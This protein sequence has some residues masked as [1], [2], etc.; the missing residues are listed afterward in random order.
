MGV[1]AVL[2]LARLAIEIGS[3]IVLIL[4]SLILAIGFQPAV[5]WLV[6]RGLSRALAVTAI[7]LLG[8]AVVGAFLALVLPDIV[9]SV[10]GLI[11]AAPEYLRRAQG[12]GGLLAELN[13]RFDLASRLQGVGGNL[14]GTLLGFVQSFGALVFNSL[15]ILIL[16][17]YFTVALPRIRAWFARLLAGDDRESFE[18]IL[19]QSTQRVG[20]YVLGMFVVSLTAGVTTFVAMLLIGVPHAAAL[21]FFVALVDLIPTIG[22]L[23][24]AV[25]A[26]TVAAIG[27]GI[28]QAI[29]TAAFFL[30]Y[31][32]VE[33]YLIHPRVMRRAIDMPAAVVIIAVL[34]GATLLGV[35]GALLAIP[36][37]AVIRVAFRELY[38]EDRLARV[39]SRSR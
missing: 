3:I 10:A 25:V 31:Q 29:A 2:A 1:L 34:I 21:A 18:E 8:L 12:G 30:L 22:A 37:A 13:Q 38:L 32:Q 5:G 36:M 6:R 20:G 39:R 19:D 14:P 4:V 16:T 26:V 33:N 9:R 27:A 24:G 23:L 15:T 35:V 28:P 11:E 17:I 7:L